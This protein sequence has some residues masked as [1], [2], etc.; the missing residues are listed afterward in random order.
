MKGS[1]SPASLPAKYS[2]YSGIAEN[3]ADELKIF[4][5]KLAG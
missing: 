3:F 2:Q 4:A 1:S 5:G